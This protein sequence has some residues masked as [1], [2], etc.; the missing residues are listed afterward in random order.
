[1]PVPTSA[2]LARPAVSR[3]SASVTPVEM[4]STPDAPV[5]TQRSTARSTATTR[6]STPIPAAASELTSAEK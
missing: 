3:A 2:T 6:G 5:T 4:L 1:M